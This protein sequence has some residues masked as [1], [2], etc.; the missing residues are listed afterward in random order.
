M[1]CARIVLKLLKTE[2]LRH[3]ICS[4]KVS[5]INSVCVCVCVARQVT[6]CR[7]IYIVCIYTV[8][9]LN[10]NPLQSVGHYMYRQFY[11]QQFY[12]LPTQCIYVFCVDLRT[13]SDYFPIQH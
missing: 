7:C 1:F 2:T 5:V 8:M 9:C 12:V 3:F 11:I 4:S 6:A 10:V 13:N